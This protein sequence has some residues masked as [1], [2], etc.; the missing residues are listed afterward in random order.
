MQKTGLRRA[1]LQPSISY[2]DP[3]FYRKDV[4]KSEFI[5]LEIELID[6]LSSTPKNSEK[7]EIFEKKI[8]TRVN[9]YKCGDNLAIYYKIKDISNNLIYSMD[10]TGPPISITIGNLDT[11]YA[12]SR[13]AENIGTDASRMA[14][15][16]VETLLN[17]HS[18]PTNFFKDAKNLPTKGVVLLQIDSLPSSIQDGKIQNN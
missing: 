8:G 5:N 16:P 11:P 15:V 6:I 17:I 7:I 9:P 2:G 13:M 4:D 14:I 18:K 12:I 10:Y 3:K 1:V